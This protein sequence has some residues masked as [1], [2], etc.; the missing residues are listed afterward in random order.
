[1]ASA[2]KTVSAK[3]SKNLRDRIKNYQQENNFENKTDAVRELWREGLEAEEVRKENA[4][5]RQE[6]EERREHA[7]RTIALTKPAA[8]TLIGWFMIAL[9][10][11]TDPTELMVGLGAVFI[12]IPTVYSL[13]KRQQSGN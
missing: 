2:K 10:I 8:V 4:G 9:A 3:A 1:M 11:D 5:L 6:L 12:L 13:I 7:E